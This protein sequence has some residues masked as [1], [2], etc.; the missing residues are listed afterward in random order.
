MVGDP[1]PHRNKLLIS[2]RGTEPATGAML[3]DRDAIR[4]THFNNALV[5]DAYTSIQRQVNDKNKPEAN[6]YRVLLADAFTEAVELRGGGSASGQLLTFAP[7]HEEWIIAHLGTAPEDDV[8]DELFVLRLR[9]SLTVGE[10]PE[11]RRVQVVLEKLKAVERFLEKSDAAFL[12]HEF[13]A[14]FER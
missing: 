11:P 4:I 3:S 2:A 9:K 1:H 7:A 12:R 13:L 10:S 6:R 5:S 8:P 14:Y